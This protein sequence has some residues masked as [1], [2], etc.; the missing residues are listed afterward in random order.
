MGTTIKSIGDVIN[1]DKDNVKMPVCKKCGKPYVWFI[2]KLEKMGKTIKL[3]VPDCNCFELEKKRK[4]QE[5]ALFKKNEKLKELFDNSMITPFF[6]EKTFNNLS[7]TIELEKCKHYAEVFE[8]KKSLGIQM[9]G[10]IGTG[11][12]TLLAGICN[13]LIERG[14]SCLF[15]TFSALMDKFSSYS[16]E[17]SGNITPLLNWL[18]GFDFVVLDDIGRETYTDKR[19]EI[20]FRIIDTLL[21]YKVVLAFT[22]NP[23]MLTKLTKIPEWRATLDRLKDTCEFKLEFKGPSLRGHKLKAFAHSQADLIE[24]VA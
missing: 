13:M 9:I 7:Q 8:P 1:A 23:N 10:N 17:N 15:T 6:K 4:K 16:Y 21:N 5:Y 12:T 22:A 19:K 3:Q 14:Y 2:K 20:A 24:E 11:K 18:A